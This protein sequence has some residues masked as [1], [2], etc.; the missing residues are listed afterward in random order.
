MNPG[1]PLPRD[2][3]ELGREALPRQARLLQS[4]RQQPNPVCPFRVVA[5][6]VIQKTGGAVE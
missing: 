5:R 4:S 3:L 1:E 6:F 2:G